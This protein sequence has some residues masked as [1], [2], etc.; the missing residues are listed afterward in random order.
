[1]SSR[2]YGSLL[3]PVIMSR[4]PAEITL[5][6]A[7]KTSQDVWEIDEIMNIILAEI[8]AREVSEKVRIS[9]KGNDKLRSKFNMPAGTTKAFVASTGSPKRSINCF[10]CNREHYASD[11]QE[12]TNTSKRIEILNSA[13]R[14]LCCLKVG[15]FAKNCR[16]NRKCKHCQ[17]KHHAIVCLKESKEEEEPVPT[18]VNA[19]ALKRGTNVLL[20]T[21][22]TYAFGENS[23][24]KVPVNVLFDSGSQK[25]YIVE[26]LM[27]MLALKSE[28]T[29]KLNLNTFGSENYIKR[30]CDRVVLNLE[31]K[32]G[33][34]PITALCHPAICS[35][36]S[37][38]IEVT[39]YPHLRGLEL[40]NSV[41]CSN[42]SIDVLIGAD[43]YHNFV[44]GEVIRGE[45][46]P[47]AVSSRL[48]WLLSGP[49]TTNVNTSI[50]ESN[51]ISNLV[52]DHFPSRE[53]AIDE[54][55]DH[56][57]IEGVLET[58][59]TRFDRR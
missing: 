14:C 8:E 42:Q 22:Q 35:P 59:I 1:V 4:M 33:F 56:C 44:L 32:H 12:V 31:T 17:G 25:S 40:A 5:Q 51:I 20:Q 6:I 19:S 49:V 47:V 58:R 7:R 16:S 11:C 38:R 29:E 53:R 55:R 21:A 45:D 41:H 46:G 37:S 36:I 2:Q 50:S 3:I 15:H 54:T 10:F 39:R 18:S 43:F 52:L 13:K 48:G 26:R 28:G 34:I 57:V 9:E 27:K 30:V 24:K 23:N